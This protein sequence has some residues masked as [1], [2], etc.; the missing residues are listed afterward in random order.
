VTRGTVKVFLVVAA[1][2]VTIALPLWSDV[3]FTD[4]GA[5]LIGTIIRPEPGG[6]RYLA[7]GREMLLPSQ[8]IQRSESDLKVLEKLPLDVELMDGSVLRGTFADFDPEIGLFLDISFGVLT[9]PV[10]SIKAVTDPVKRLRYAGSPFMA[11]AGASWYFPVLS[12]ASSFGPSLGIDLAAE[13]SVPLLRGLS[14]GFDARYAFADF[15][16]SQSVNYSFVSVAPEASYRLLFLRTRDDWLRNLTP[17]VSAGVGPVYIN[18]LDPG[19]Y[20]SQMG[21][22]SLGVNMKLG[23]DVDIFKGVGIRLQGRSDLYLQQGN[24]FVLLSIGLMASYDR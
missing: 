4:D 15:L 22:L 1:L 10:Q 12:G 3:V 2:S 6:M 7:Y 23:L 21:E 9:V 5:I 19:G 20:P 14:A 11:R 17:F 18:L 24:P 16:P 8:S 13:W